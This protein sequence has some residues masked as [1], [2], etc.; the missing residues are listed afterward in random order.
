MLLSDK[1]TQLFEVELAVFISVDRIE[2]G[3][4]SNLE[5]GQILSASAFIDTILIKADNSIAVCV[6]G[7]EHLRGLKFNESHVNIDRLRSDLVGCVAKAFHQLHGCV[8]E[9]ALAT[10]ARYQIPRALTNF[11]DFLVGWSTLSCLIYCRVIV[12]N[13]IAT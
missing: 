2:L 9:L 6:A 1:F 12:S 8:I 7:L 10:N 5:F 4:Q 13:L 11:I 3:S